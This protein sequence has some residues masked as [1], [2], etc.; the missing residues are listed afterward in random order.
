[1][2]AKLYLE[3][4]NQEMINKRNTADLRHI[5]RKGD[6]I[7]ANRAISMNFLQ[8]C[9]TM[10][11]FVTL[12]LIL[13]LTGCP[14]GGGS[15]FVTC[16]DPTHWGYPFQEDL[17]S[18]CCE[19]GKTASQCCLDHGGIAV[20]LSQ[21]SIP[22]ISYTTLDGFVDFGK[23]KLTVTIPADGD[24]VMTELKGRV[25]ISGGVCPD[26]QCPL[27]VMLVELRSFQDNFKTHNGKTVSGV[28]VRNA[29]T[30]TGTRLS[31][32]TILMDATNKLA[33]EATIDG[34]KQTAVLNPNAWF[35]GTLKYN[36]SRWTD[37]G[38]LRNNK[39][40]IDGKFADENVK[41][42]LDIT[43]WA[44]DCRPVILPSVQCRP[45]IEIG[46]PG[47]VH[48]DS[49]FSMLENLQN[50][51]DLC[52]ALLSP[53]E[54]ICTSG[55]SDEFPGFSCNKQPLPS[56]NDKVEVAKLLKFSWKDANGIVFSNQYATE[57]DQM[58]AFPV[59]LTVENKWGR[60][61]SAQLVAPESYAYCPENA[62]P[63]EPLETCLEFEHLTV[64]KEYHVSDMFR[65]G[66]VVVVVKPYEDH[67]RVPIWGGG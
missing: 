27:Q 15:R 54:D 56:S 34:Q 31:D 11:V 16:S 63:F 36:A 61:V 52:D 33:L 23:T 1:M 20:N 6:D 57:L 43:I 41:A 9:R 38:Q 17:F 28:F 42:S 46:F 5:P 67:N 66:H 59:T 13:C 19:Y 64:G 35:T 7:I 62:P 8:R 60:S 53:Y 24:E 14:C 29:N 32:G 37:T 22:D 50:S 25:A 65:E 12:P 45:D 3:R 58:P 49:D 2:Q 18:V 4:I 39:I 55:G 30:W 47:Y 40:E 26:P 10:A 48:F 21:L 51:Q 44:T